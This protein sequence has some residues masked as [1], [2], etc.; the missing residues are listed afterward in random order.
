MKKV[1]DLKWVYITC[2]VSLVSMSFGANGDSSFSLKKLLLM[3]GD[4]ISD[5]VDLE[6]DCNN[7]HVEFDQS[8][9]NPLCLDCH[10]QIAEDIKKNSGFH[11]L[12]KAIEP[13]HCRSCHTDHKGRDAEVVQLD[14]ESFN[15]DQT[16]HP[17]KGKHLS[18]SCAQCH[19]NNE[20]FRLEGDQCNDCH[21]QQNPHEK[22]LGIECD[23]CH[24]SLSWKKSKFNHDKT[25]FK[26]E[27]KHTEVSC[28]SCHFSNVFEN[29]PEQCSGCHTNDDIHQNLF[30][31]ECESCHSS[32]GWNES[33][34]DHNKKSDFKLKNQHQDVA[35][36]LCHEQPQPKKIKPENCNSCHA[37]DD[38]HSGSNGSRCESCHSERGWG[39]TSFDHNRKTDFSLKGKHKSLRCV[40]C[41]F[42]K[43]TNSPTVRGCFN[44]HKNDDPHGKA[45]G[46][47]CG[48]CHSEKGW[49][50]SIV[51][52]HETTVFPLLGMHKSLSCGEC[53]LTKQFHEVGSD[54]YTCHQQ[55]DHHKRRLG[56]DCGGCHNPN[57][58]GFWLFDHDKQTEFRLEGA[59]K[60][61]KC[62]LCHSDSLRDPEKPPLKC[63]NCHRE[64]DFHRGAF[65]RDCGQCHNS[66]SFSSLKKAKE[67]NNE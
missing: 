14:R 30:G 19:K 55:D 3:P 33:H 12:N 60:N 56:E 21:K 8:N 63:G 58:W 52:S 64:D 34:F 27:N 53:H 45:L 40:S 61:L 7:C 49:G 54:C 36:K 25:N 48:Q 5:H 11:G 43:I 29:A 31:N 66:Q 65:G 1:R 6:N 22:A 17:L 50:R 41:H 35:C 37:K 57:D 13:A 62:Q 28:D 47:E 4:L 46:E 32:K 42:E 44:C 38:I 9:Q 15:H 10:E 26:L 51:F 67:S 20:G 16:N 2:F 59:H 24:S 23:S 18:L 39:K